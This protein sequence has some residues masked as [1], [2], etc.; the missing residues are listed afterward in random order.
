M[1]ARIRLKLPAHKSLFHA[2]VKEYMDLH[3]HQ[4]L[5]EMNRSYSSEF[6]KVENPNQALS[7]AL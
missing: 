6:P 2:L 4:A 3:K 1:K 7:F 5:E